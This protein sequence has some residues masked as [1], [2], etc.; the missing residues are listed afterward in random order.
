MAT[1]PIVT[2]ADILCGEYGLAL[3]DAHEMV[4][5][6]YALLGRLP[7]QRELR[8]LMVAFADVEPGWFGANTAVWASLLLDDV[9]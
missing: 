1:E 9:S 8:R 4:E 3:D 7:R 5:T 6:L 2:S